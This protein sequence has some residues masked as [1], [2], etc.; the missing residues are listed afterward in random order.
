MTE[1]HRKLT[2]V[3]ETLYQLGIGRTSLYR[4]FAEGVLVPVHVGRRVFVPQ[5]NIDDYV[6]R[7]TAAATK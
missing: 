4:L 3:P 5:A 1:L 7:L 2:P 6:A